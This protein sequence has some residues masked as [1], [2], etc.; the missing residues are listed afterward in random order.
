MDKEF[1]EDLARK[2]ANVCEFKSDFPHDWE[3]VFDGYVEGFK[4]AQRLVN[5]NDHIAVVRERF[6][7]FVENQKD[8]DPEIAKIVNDNFWDML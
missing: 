8:L 5:N 7:E 3:S 1:I 2:Y 4:T 6:S